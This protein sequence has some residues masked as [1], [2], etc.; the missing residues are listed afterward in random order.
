MRRGESVSGRADVVERAT[1]YPYPIPP[2]SFL[3][4]GERTSPLPTDWSR[5]GRTGVLAVGSN[6]APEVL[7]RK[8]VVEEGD[9]PAVRAELS[10]FDVVY[11]AHIS[12]YGAVPAALQVSEETTVTTYVLYLNERQLRL[13]AKT[14]P[15]YDLALLHNVKCDLEDGKSLTS[16]ASYL[17]KHG[18]LR[19]G[20]LPAAL[21]EVEASRRKFPSLTETEVLERVRSELAPTIPLE[22]F[23][24]ESAGDRQVARGRTRFLVAHSIPFAGTDWEPLEY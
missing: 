5:E 22:R 1:A 2:Q 9:I 6:A 18:C 20:D 21:A 10:D 14:E 11:S 8:G 3:Q 19:V 23:I 13:M 24:E 7:I 15:N 16:V 4:V 12:S 17:S